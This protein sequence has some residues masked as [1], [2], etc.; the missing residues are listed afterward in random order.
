VAFLGLLAPLLLAP[1]AR[2]EQEP[3]YPH[4]ANV[5]LPVHVDARVIEALS[6]WDLVVLNNAWS[7]GQLAEL[8]AR[9]PDIKIFFYVI[10]YVV[11]LSPSSPWE[12]FN[13]SY[14]RYID[15]WWYDADGRM[16]SDWPGAGMVN[17][18]DLAPQAPLGSWREFFVARVADLVAL[19]PQ[20]D[21]IYLDNFWRQLSWQQRYRRLDSDCNPTH[22][23][24]AATASWTRTP[25]STRCGTGGWRRSLPPSAPAS[26]SWKASASVRWRSS[27]T[28]RTI[29]SSGSMAH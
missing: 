24:G 4:L 27:A 29:T 21:G 28:A 2:A 26:T 18:T 12:R 15:L 17:V 14:A 5:Y 23:P 8:R 16:A 13:T 1:P 6:Q 11:S 7:Q 10:P 19:H 20:L 9:N 22:N 25:G 3:A